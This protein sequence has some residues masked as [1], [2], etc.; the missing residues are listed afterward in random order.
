MSY[1]QM[2]DW[3]DTDA[4]IQAND[5][6]IKMLL[7]ALGKAEGALQTAVELEGGECL[8][9]ALDAVQLAIQQST[10]KPTP[11]RKTG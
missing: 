4:I 8:L 9:Y 11:G 5:A 10:K 3:L 2:M 6:K 1:K 7:A